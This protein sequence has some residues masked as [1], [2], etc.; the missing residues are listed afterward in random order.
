MDVGLEGKIKIEKLF[1]Q[2][3]ERIL[4]YEFVL[5]HFP[6]GKNLKV[7]DFGIHPSNISLELAK[8]GH[9]VTGVTIEPYRY[10]EEADRLRVKIL[11][12]D[13]FYLSLPSS[14]FD[15]A[16]SISTQE[17]I[18]IYSPQRFYYPN[19]DFLAMAKIHTSLKEGGKV[20]FT[21]PYGLPK[22]LVGF[23]RIYDDERLSM[24]FEGFQI[25]ETA[26]CKKSSFRK[27]RMAWTTREDLQGKECSS[28]LSGSVCIL[29]EKTQKSFQT[30]YSSS[31]T[32]P[33]LLKPFQGWDF[34]GW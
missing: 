20:L 15:V 8:L 3:P 28:K 1:K 24:L 34:Q 17:H 22:I 12:G 31:K 5:K 19:G 16:L 4:E 2:G 26:Y 29:A 13:I 23:C 30:P 32:P 21:V 27:A 9:K 33:I 18:G 10:Q 11:L 6:E 7:L 14:Y 25:K